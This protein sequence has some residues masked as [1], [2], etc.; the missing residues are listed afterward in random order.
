MAKS[1]LRTIGLCYKRVNI[2]QLNL[3][4]EGK[5]DH[6]IFD[7]EKEGFTLLGIAGIKDIIR[8]EVP[9]SMR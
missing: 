4:D 8:A 7:Y 9:H 3:T 6:G 1:A 5:D 2:N